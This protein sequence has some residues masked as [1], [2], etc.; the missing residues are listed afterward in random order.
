MRTRY[1][2]QWFSHV[3]KKSEIARWTAQCTLLGTD[4]GWWQCLP[5]I[6]KQETAEC[7]GAESGKVAG[8]ATPWFPV[9]AVGQSKQG[10]GV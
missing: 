6:T 7:E 2:D 3:R 1:I 10:Q 8:V 5:C 9:G 4:F